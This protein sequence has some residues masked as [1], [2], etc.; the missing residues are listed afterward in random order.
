MWAHFVIL[1]FLQKIS[2]S[3]AGGKFIK[4]ENCTSTNTSLKIER[5]DIVNGS[6]N[7]I[8]N[9]FKPLEQ[10]FVWNI[11]QKQELLLKK[12]IFPQV[13]LTPFRREG[14]YFRPIG[15][16]P[17]FEACGAIKSGTK[18]NPFVMAAVFII[19][20]A[21]PNL[22]KPCPFSG[23]VELLNFNPS[24]DMFKFI[25]KGIFKA[26]L[27]FYNDFD[28]SILLISLIYAKTSWLKFFQCSIIHLMKLS[29]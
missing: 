13:K 9:V 24:S 2:P 15:K 16:F 7:A 29:N 14:S 18:Q 28:S 11:F 10:V 3:N 1:L 26:N 23:R 19:L 20:N 8:V 12:V 17:A 21:L 4:L 6:F 25:S 22:G 5:C 27:Q